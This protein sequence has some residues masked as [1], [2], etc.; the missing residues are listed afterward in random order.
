M[1]VCNDLQQMGHGIRIRVSCVVGSS[2]DHE[3][4]AAPELSKTALF[5][6]VRRLDRI[7]S[8]SQVVQAIL[9]RS[10]GTDLLY[11]QWA[12]REIV[13]RAGFGFRPDDIDR[14]NDCRGYFDALSSRAD[15]IG[16][17]T[18]TNSQSVHLAALLSMREE[19]LQTMFVR[20]KA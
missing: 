6:I 14:L 4:K 2:N 16:T 11:Q 12:V 13:E 19:C 10:R 8:G 9:Q 1:Q 20:P 17:S 18:Y 5:C 7:G 3:A 15:A